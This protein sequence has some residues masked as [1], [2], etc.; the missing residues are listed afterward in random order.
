M[1]TISLIEE[2][3]NLFKISGL[4]IQNLKASDYS[5]EY[6]KVQKELNINSARAILWH[7]INN[8]YIIPKCV[9]CSRN[10]KYA[11]Y[12]D[13]YAIHCS[14]K[15]R[16]TDPNIDEY[17]KSIVE[18]REKTMIEK[19]GVAKISHLP[20]IRKK[21][22][23][24]METRYGYRNSLQ[25]P[26]LKAK[27]QAT[28]LERYG[29]TN[30][31][32][33]TRKKAAH[34]MTEKYGVQHTLQSSELKAKAQATNLE[35]YG[36]T[37]VGPST[38]KKAVQTMVDRYGVE[39]AL[40]NPE[41][42]NKVRQTNLDRYGHPYPAMNEDVKLKTRQTNLKK[43]NAPSHHQ[44]HISSENLDILF[45]A[46]LFSNF[47]KG[48]TYID[49]SKILGVTLKTVHT[50]AIR[51]QVVDLFST[52]SANSYETTIQEI[53]ER[54]QISY[55]RNNKTILNGKHLDY[56]IPK[57]NLAIE[58]GAIYYHTELEYG[59]GKTYHLDKWQQCKDQGITLLQYF[60]DEIFK[61]THLIESKILRTC[62]IKVSVIGARKC[63]LR[64]IT[65]AQEREFLN[66]W[67]L[68]GH[69]NR[70]NWVMGAYYNDELVAVM[71]I[72]H[73][74][75]WA[76]IERWATNTNYSYPGLFSRMISAFQRETEFTG[77]LVTFSNNMYGDGHVY[78]SSGFVKSN[79]DKIKPGYWYFKDD[80]KY[81]RIKFQKH[82]LAKLFDLDPIYVEQQGEFKIME[83]QGYDRFWDAGHTKWIKNY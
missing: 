39:H 6:L 32:P 35:R 49:V 8:C 69:M 2:S 3:M 77:Q 82:K 11:S 63:Q 34:T 9:V 44:S 24:T 21:A 28:N 54:H 1:K 40:Q 66:H 75:N 29:H 17:K 79:T 31:G 51:Y 52:G 67:H 81:S 48:K 53:L 26:E 23:D 80:E 47:I 15:C 41:I 33:S 13:G 14:K 42:K 57:H 37:N 30:V 61:Y 55:Q 74:N 59:R 71:S 38:R 19:Y 76:K 72:Y 4:T 73:K 20:E 25:S 18:K 68:Q 27:A 58:V 65:P 60:D 43:Y 62:D 10:S 56:Y 45:D 78:E 22:C 12:L 16:D 83:M 46:T 64:L 7:V 36:H 70:R 5:S 50:Y